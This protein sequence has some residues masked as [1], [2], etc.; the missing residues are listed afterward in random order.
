MEL[1]STGEE[2]SLRQVASVAGTSTMAVYTHFGG[3][4]GLWLDVR[5]RAFDALAERLRELEKTDDPVADLIA[6]GA[7]YADRALDDRALFHA[8]FEVR[9]TETQPAVAAATF[10]VLVEC[11]ERAVDVGRLAN[12]CDP[13]ATAIR[14][15]AMT[16]GVLMLVSTDALPASALDDH[17][18]PMY[19]AQLVALGDGPRR[20]TRS[21]RAGWATRAANRARSDP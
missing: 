6:A 7:A 9:R 11:I 3:M 14:L 5:E 13:I 16:H 2:L 17:L 19:I 21:T 8:M 1:L 20:A 10:A 12:R 18:P 15:W 4:P